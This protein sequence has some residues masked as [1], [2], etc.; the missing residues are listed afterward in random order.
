VVYG[1]E[2]SGN[3]LENFADLFLDLSYLM[4]TSFD[5]A[6][7]L[8]STSSSSFSLCF[9][10]DLSSLSFLISFD[11]A[12]SLIVLVYKSF[13]MANAYSFDLLA[14]KATA[15]SLSSLHLFSI[16]DL[17]SI[18]SSLLTFARDFP[19]DFPILAS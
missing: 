6:V 2:V 16:L 8:I 11:L 19:F 17:S 14:A 3:L 12:P 15:C 10:F 7:C 1:S 9:A 5:T 4:L 18:I 13:I